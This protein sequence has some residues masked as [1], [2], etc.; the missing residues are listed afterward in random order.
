MR[1][2]GVVPARGG[3]KGLPGK[4]TR[5]LAGV[6]LIGHALLA[7]GQVPSLTRVV[8]TTDDPDVA[9]VARRW[10]GDVPFLRPPELAGD[11]TPM[12]PV[13]SHALL[14]AE[15]EESSRYDLV[16]L[17]D[18]TSPLRRPQDIEAAISELGE[19]DDVVGVVSVSE[20]MFH[21]SWVGVVDRG[22][23][24]LE[25]FYDGGSGVTRR[26]D[27]KQR[28]LRINGSFYVWQADFVRDMEAAWLDSAPHAGFEID[29]LHAFSIDDLTEFRVVEALVAQG[30]VD[31][32]WLS[33][34]D[35]SGEDAPTA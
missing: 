19:R 21:P 8:V 10:G 30:V 18:P 20:P 24:V 14:A 4:N 13:L 32:P 3:S 34:V 9:D 2:L 29:E 28:Y 25:R 12:A 11:D 33:R 31:L 23:G 22:D 35:P 7:L 1:V 27:N 26:Q 5:E 6:P 17:A 15:L 16:V